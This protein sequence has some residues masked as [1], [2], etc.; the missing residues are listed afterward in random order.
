MHPQ[1]LLA[2]ILSANTDTT[3]DL[4]N[5]TFYELPFW[6][7]SPTQNPG[8][9]EFA[10]RENDEQRAA[11][12]RFMTES[13]FRVYVKDVFIREFDLERQQFEIVIGPSRGVSFGDFAYR[14]DG[15]PALERDDRVIAG[16]GSL[17][18]DP[19]SGD[20]ETY[21]APEPLVTPVP[22]AQAPD[23]S[24]LISGGVD[25][26]DDDLFPTTI[27]AEVFARIAKVH[28]I[29]KRSYAELRPF[30][31][32]LLLADG[33]SPFLDC[34]SKDSRI[35]CAL[36]QNRLPPPSQ[37]PIPECAVAIAQLSKISGEVAQTLVDAAT[38]ERL[39][40]K[41]Q[42]GLL[43]QQQ[44]NITARD[45]AEALSALTK[46]LA[47]DQMW[48]KLQS[49]APP[50]QAVPIDHPLRTTKLCSDLISRLLDSRHPASPHGR[51]LFD[52]LANHIIPICEQAERTIKA[53]EEALD[54][55]QF[56]SLLTSTKALVPKLP[57]ANAATD[58]HHTAMRACAPFQMQ[59][60]T[61]AC[62]A[63]CDHQYGCMNVN[64][65][66]SGLLQRCTNDCLSNHLRANSTDP[67]QPR[68]ACLGSKCGDP[69]NACISKN[70]RQ[71]VDPPRTE[72]HKAAAVV[73][74]ESTLFDLTKKPG[75]S[76]IDGPDL[77]TTTPIFHGTCNADEPTDFVNSC[78]IYADYTLLID[79]RL[80]IHLRN[81]KLDTLHSYIGPGLLGPFAHWR[82]SPK[83]TL[84]YIEVVDYDANASRQWV[85]AQLSPKMCILGSA[86]TLAE[87]IRL[88]VPKACRL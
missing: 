38:A 36:A 18:H 22:A 7:L 45:A 39:R 20:R 40:L 12:A 33:R 19:Y 52:L 13:T 21:F 47:D 43:L 26:V 41:A 70:T 72:P 11:M 34:H 32:R 55:S 62:E 64:T 69:R 9:N 80:F 86:L 74:G 2:L 83:S 77:V 57:T 60:A 87:A 51:S 23:F 79:T 75:I 78:T 84:V 58:R 63:I 29:Q 16:I 67:L 65:Q 4:T 44:P 3:F 25:Y 17:R 15:H 53:A 1:L 5:E 88:P 73:L 61:L 76:W 8:D 68:L 27:R 30:R 85:A 10:R 50:T 24:R 28:L 42:A 59:A 48:M 56:V 66:D 82:S 54:A 14:N 35:T 71:Q 6:A 49:A 81:Q 31:V 37:S 46:N